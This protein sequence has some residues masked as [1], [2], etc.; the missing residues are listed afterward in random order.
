VLVGA[1]P[2]ETF[3]LCKQLDELLWEPPLSVKTA[4]A[5]KVPPEL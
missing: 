4:L 5:V 3:M 2:P 1:A